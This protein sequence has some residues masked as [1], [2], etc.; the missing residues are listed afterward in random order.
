MEPS[1]CG[2]G[3]GLYVIG[4]CQALQ[5]INSRSNFYFPQRTEGRG[6]CL[7]LDGGFSMYLQ[8][9]TLSLRQTHHLD[10]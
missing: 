9:H 5:P 8:T 10:M 4:K 1:C 7:G 2:K 3:Q 6:A